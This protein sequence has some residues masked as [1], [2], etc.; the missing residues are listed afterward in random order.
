M[1]NKG[2]ALIELI[3]VLAIIGIV[4]VIALPIIVGFY[5]TATNVTAVVE[6]K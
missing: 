3:V 4:F 1:K 5:D 2:F 6:G